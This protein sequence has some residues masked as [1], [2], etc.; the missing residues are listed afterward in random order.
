MFLRA[1]RT[2][3]SGPIDRA[4]RG[5]DDGGGFGGMMLDGIM[6]VMVEHVVRLRAGADR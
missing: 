2:C 4:A 3:G 6:V 5:G 1:G